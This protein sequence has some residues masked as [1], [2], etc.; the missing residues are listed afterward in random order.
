M[1]LK[2]LQLAWFKVY[3]SVKD[4]MQ[5]L[6]NQRE[7]RNIGIL[8]ETDYKALMYQ[9]MDCRCHRAKRSLIGGICINAYD[10]AKGDITEEKNFKFMA[11]KRK[12]AIR[13]L[14]LLKEH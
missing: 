1:K 2:G 3:D 5:N 12:Q 9:I 13:A 7:K 6:K 11:S 8:V 14:K 4:V 10:F